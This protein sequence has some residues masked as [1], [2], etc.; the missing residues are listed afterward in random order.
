MPERGDIVMLQFSPQAG[1]EQAGMRPAFVL[2]PRRYN[3]KVGLMLACP[4][5]SKSKGYPFEVPLPGNLKT[6]GVIL[7]DHVRSLDWKHRHAR[8]I[9]I[10][11]KQVTLEVVGRLDLLLH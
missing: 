3:A 2:S 6:H 7:A 11:P 4:I 8:L 5:T 9:E 1:R 10:A